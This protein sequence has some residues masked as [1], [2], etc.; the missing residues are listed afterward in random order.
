MKALQVDRSLIWILP[1][2]KGLTSEAEKVK[3]AFEECGPDA[4]GVSISKEELAG[5]RSLT[6]EE[7]YE[8][9]GIE[10]YYSQFLSTFGQVRIPPPCYL[11]AQQIGDESG[12]PVIPLDM[13]EELYSAV[14][15]ECVRTLDLLRESF[16]VKRIGRMRFNL[17][18]PEEFIKDWDA[19][20]NGSRGFCTL[21]K[22]RERHM[23]EVL[24]GMAGKYKNILAVIEMERASGIIEILL[25]ESFHKTNS[26]TSISKIELPPSN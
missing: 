10:W 9:S 26:F 12:V 18:S 13:N 20:V 11:A 4:I 25:N 2:I 1:V 16:L 21:Q 24:R 23:V 22:K 7:E 19:R 8:L 3:S 6:G 14:Y 5:L 15:C 17:S